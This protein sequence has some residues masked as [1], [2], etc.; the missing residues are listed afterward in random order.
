MKRTALVLTL[1]LVML[2]LSCLSVN[3]VKAET[4]GPPTYLST[5][6]AFPPDMILISSPQNTAYHAHSIFVN[7]TVTVPNAIYD[8][9]YSVDNGS[10]QRV[11]NL[12]KVSEVPVPYGE[13]LLP[14]YIRVTYM[15]TFFLYGL[16]EGN[17]SVTIYQG[18]LYTGKWQRYEIALWTTAEFS[19]D[20]GPPILKI[21]EIGTNASSQ[22]VP[23]NFTIN[24]PA[25]WMAYSLDQQTNIT[26][27]GNT[28]LVGLSEGSHSLIVYANDTAGNMVSSQ[29]IFFTV[30]KAQPKPELEPFP[31]TLVILAVVVVAL[32]SLGLLVY[33][34]KRKR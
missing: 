28:T 15:G 9:G 3:E 5:Q 1:L 7:F 29:T 25:S 33:F 31:T 19:I 16:S 8:V 2:P 11:T 23:F 30:S 6:S 22:Q 32:V 17:H 10:I 20:T 26:I 24:E 21:L 14:P 13:I 27:S 4:L 12:V 34:K 18:Y